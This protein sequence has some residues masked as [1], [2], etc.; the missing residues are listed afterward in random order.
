VRALLQKHPDA[1][2]GWY[3][4]GSLLMAEGNASAGMAAFDHG[5]SLNANDYLLWNAIGLNWSYSNE[6][7]KGVDAF[8]RSLALDGSFEEA[9][10]NLG[11]SQLLQGKT[12]DSIESF[13][14]GPRHQSAARPR[15]RQPD[16]R[17]H[18]GRPTRRG[19]ENVRSVGHRRSQAG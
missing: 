13:K 1:E 16:P 19:G 2:P 5:T 9:W 3:T 17:L 12:D 10:N 18:Q 4:L 7:D 15:A 8:Q 14:R 11:Y 6:L